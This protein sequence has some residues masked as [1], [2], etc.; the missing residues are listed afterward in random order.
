MSSGFNLSALALHHRALTLFFLLLFTLAGMLAYATLGQKEEP[1]FK[2]KVMVVRVLWP[3]ATAEEIEQQVTDKLERKLQDTPNLD[4]LRSY[5]RP[6]ESVIFVNLAGSTRAKA[7][8]DTW[9]QVR[10]KVADMAVE[11]P[12]GVIGPFFNDE[13]G[14]TYTNIYAVTGEG[15]GYAEVKDYADL[16]RAELLRVPGV[17]KVDLLGVQEEKIYVEFS[18]PKLAALGLDSQQL[19]AALA[20]QNRVAPAG[21]VLT[22]SANLQVRVTGGFESVA[23][24]ESVALRANGRSFRLGDVASVRRA[25]ADPPATKMRHQGRE[26]I[27]VAVTMSAAGDVVT[28]GRGLDAATAA[29]AARLPLGIEIA[30]VA[31]QPQ[32]V[33]RS[34]G[35]FKRALGEALAIVLAVSFLSLGL[36]TGLVVALT[37]PIVLAMTF[38]GMQLAGIDLHRISFGALIIA[39]GLL[40][41]DAMIAVEMMARKLE[42]GL[43]KLAA[44]SYAYRHTAWPMLTGTLVTAA[45]FMPIGLSS[46][47][48]S[49]YTGSIFW[50]TLIALAVSWI[51]AVTFTPYLGTLVLRER[52]AA[53][54]HD[55]YAT[56][57]YARLRRLLDWCIEHRWKTIGLTLV[58]FAAS[59]AAFQL[60]PKQFFP[61]SNRPEMIISLRHS[62]DTAQSVT[63]ASVRRVEALLAADPDVAQASAYVGRSAPRFYLPLLQE[64][65]AS[66]NYAEIVAVAHDSAARD[67]VMA[68]L[69][70][71]FARDFAGVRARIER[72][73]NGPPVGYPVQFRV[74]GADPAVAARYAE[75]VAR[76]VQAHPATLDV[77]LDWFERQRALRLVVDQDK[78][79]A[80]GLTS[81]Q[82]REALAASLSG[83][84]VTTLRDGDRA[85]EVVVRAREDERSL[86]GAVADITLPTPSG[87]YVPVAQV[88]RVELALEEARTW[89][90]DRLP[91]VTVRADVAEGVQAPDVTAALLPQL[92]PVRAQLPPGYYLDAGGA[93][94]ESRTNEGAIQGMFP[95]MLL[96]LVTLLMLQLQS[97]SKT[98]MVLLTAPLGM[99]GVVAA[100]LAF[101]AP[102][103]FVAQL[104]IIALFGMIMRNS[105]ILVDQIRQDFAAGHPA[106]TAI[107]E[108][109]VRRFRPIVLTAAAMVLAMIPLTRSELW[110]PMAMAIMGGLVV[111]TVLTILF[112]PALYAA[113]Y[114]VRRTGT[115][116]SRSPMHTAPHAP[117]AATAAP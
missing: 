8:D 73:P 99:I 47:T 2:F 61:S 76:V 33:R 111:A 45:G 81:A 104:G 18:H 24:V 28:L 17:E 22:G 86:A 68:R 96:V 20:Q 44:A 30:T 37:V 113:W 116:E 84:A 42:E 40:V 46:S 58:A 75:E 66:P 62:E 57:F 110:G 108:S 98:A 74:S 88:A 93:W 54:A 103:G 83:A 4:Y 1:E 77:N 87:R 63:E 94:H 56:P 35:E 48:A 34:S 49:E 101:S 16:L 102:M 23:D 43:D 64:E 15:F 67:R 117:A 12:A 106:W 109:A 114:R 112:V 78:A 85:I 60:V 6:G 14:D 19:F 38:L 31:D 21:R 52:P 50:V 55:P 11:L 32:A 41:D 26:A 29:L 25:Y 7:V 70:Q 71:E 105:V 53:A 65:F 89:R 95:V 51:V 82:I 90:R 3:G 36:R 10:K 13:F 107:R 79:R 80:L 39:L 9:Y 97:F 5:S 115:L 59:L 72:L 91:T 27:G 92:E 69:R 100:L